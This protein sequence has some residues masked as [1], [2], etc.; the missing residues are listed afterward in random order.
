MRIIRKKQEFSLE[1]K[2]Y[3]KKIFADRG[4]FIYPP[5]LQLYNPLYE[6]VKKKILDKKIFPIKKDTFLNRQAT[7]LLK[8]NQYI[9]SKK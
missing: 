6:K 8:F 7:A 9:E 2:E 5:G 4:I 3:I 1:I